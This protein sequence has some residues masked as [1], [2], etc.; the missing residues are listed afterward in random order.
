MFDNTG[1]R[2]LEQG[3][4]LVW[5]KQK[6]INQNIANVSTPD[7]K[8][9]TVDFGVTLDNKCKCAYHP[10][11]ASY[12]GLD[13]EGLGLTISVTDEEN[14]NQTLDGNNVDI[15][16]ES[17]ALLDAQLQYSALSEKMMK[18]FEMIKTAL[19]KA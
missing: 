16:K 5:Q 1:F 10:K 18:E 7:Y 2:F 12:R 19:S 14:T 13:D 15:E 8:A 9:K 17:L 6:I 3:L 11:S 4:G